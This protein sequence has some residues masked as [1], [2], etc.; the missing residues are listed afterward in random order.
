MKPLEF[1]YQDTQIHFLINHSDDNIMI[2]ATEMAKLF[3]RRTKDFLKTDHAKAFIKVVERAP[4]GAHSDYK[5]IDNRGHMG[6][7]FD[8]RLALKFAAWLSPEFEV[9]VF[10]MIDEIMFGSLKQYRDAM[11]QEVKLKAN[12]ANLKQM[13][14]D[15]PCIENALAYFDNEDQIKQTQNTKRK[16][17]NSQIS[18]FEDAII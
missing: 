4:N 10:S 3:N 7:Y 8:R 17:I 9:W 13:L 15:A 16:A 14:L 5:I 12:K 6:I 1:I 2:N 18:L 11:K